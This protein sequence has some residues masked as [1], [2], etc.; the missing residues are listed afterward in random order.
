M[1]HVLILPP[2]V[3]RSARGREGA[4]STESSPAPRGTEGPRCPR[5]SGC[6]G[7]SHRSSTMFENG[8]HTH[9]LPPPPLSLSL[10]GRDKALMASATAF[11][12]L[13]KQRYNIYTMHPLVCRRTLQHTSPS[14]H[15]YIGHV[16][17]MHY[18]LQVHRN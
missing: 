16:I 12:E 17:S 18:N 6:Y 14:I 4:E 1:S 7:N 5:V 15:T 10:T 2:R 8:S 9:I 11:K 13:Q 3:R